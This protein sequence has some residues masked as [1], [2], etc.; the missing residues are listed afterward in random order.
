M[1]NAKCQKRYKQATLWGSKK[2]V[3]TSGLGQKMA[4]KETCQGNG[5][6]DERK[7]TFQADEQRQGRGST[8]ASKVPLGWS[9]CVG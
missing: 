9:K 3:L 5:D 2:E 4:L 1:S 7:G 6:G 8:V